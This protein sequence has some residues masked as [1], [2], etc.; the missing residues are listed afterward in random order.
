MQ[1]YDLAQTPPSRAKLA[2]LDIGSR[3]LRSSSIECSTSG[4]IWLSD[5]KLLVQNGGQVH[6]LEVNQE[7][8]PVGRGTFHVPPD[9]AC[10]YMYVN[11]AIVLEKKTLLLGEQVLLNNCVE[12]ATTVVPTRDWIFV[13]S[14]RSLT[15]YG[16]D[17][18]LVGTRAFDHN[19]F[20]C[21]E[22]EDAAVAYGT[23]DSAVLR[24][25]VKDRDIVVTRIVDVCAEDRSDEPGTQRADKR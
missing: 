2:L 7:G 25:E 18:G 16:K 8:Q 3:K 1:M 6:I 13:G 9:G 23:C 17:G 19:V 14:G 15:V 5:K 10:L 21:S 12:D 22:G 20:V 24:V 4:P 11:Q